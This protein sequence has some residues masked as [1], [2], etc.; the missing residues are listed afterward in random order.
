[1]DGKKHTI[2]KL[3][4]PFV[5]E[6]LKQLAGHEVEL[7][8]SRDVILAMRPI[9]DARIRLPIILCYVPAIDMLL[10]HD[11]LKNTRAVMF[12]TLLEQNIIPVD[13]AAIAEVEQWQ[14]QVQE[15]G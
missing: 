10:D 2:S 4:V 3:W 13:G 9:E 6:P 1:V 15:K 7:V 12:K 14:L 5:E 8:I 11:F